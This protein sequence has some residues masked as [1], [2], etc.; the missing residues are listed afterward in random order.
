M[1]KSL[2]W[3]S[4][5]EKPSWWR[6]VKQMYFAPAALMALTHSRASNEAG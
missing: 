5:I 1:V 3:L 2:Y 6:V 4:N